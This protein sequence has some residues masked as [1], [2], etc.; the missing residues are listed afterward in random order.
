VVVTDGWAYVAIESGYVTD[1][2]GDHATVYDI[3]DDE[4]PKESFTYTCRN[5]LSPG[6]I[7]AGL[8]EVVIIN[9]S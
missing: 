5:E 6:A 2:A 9:V 1:T 4:V 8:A 7:V 3:E